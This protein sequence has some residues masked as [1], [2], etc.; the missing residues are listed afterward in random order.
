MFYIKVICDKSYL[1]FF[2]IAHFK[3]YIYF[4][5]YKKISSH[6]CKFQNFYKKNTKIEE[7][8]KNTCLL[9]LFLVTTYSK[10][11]KIIGEHLSVFSC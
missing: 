11:I 9:F 7:F 8:A 2:T 5:L 1:M 3:Y 4:F 6:F 10:F